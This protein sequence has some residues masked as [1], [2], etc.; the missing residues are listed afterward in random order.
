MVGGHTRPPSSITPVDH[1]RFMAG[2]P[3]AGISICRNEPV[4]RAGPFWDHLDLDGLI[5]G[6]EVHM[7]DRDS[8]TA[9]CLLVLPGDRVHHDERNGCSRVARSQP[10]WIADL[11]ARPSTH[12]AANLSRCRSESRCP[13]TTDCWSARRPRCFHMVP[14]MVR[15]TESVSRCSSRVEP[16]LDVVWQE[17]QRADVERFAELLDFANVNLHG[18]DPV[19]ERHSVQIFSSR[20]AQYIAPCNSGMGAHASSDNVPNFPRARAPPE[21]TNPATS[22]ACSS[23]PRPGHEP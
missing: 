16:A 10:L 8:R 1:E 7:D 19:A 21:R 11:S 23:A 9:G 6:V 2:T 17:F 15:P 22:P 14:R 18:A 12:A 5:A 4:L 3:S 13:G 20:R